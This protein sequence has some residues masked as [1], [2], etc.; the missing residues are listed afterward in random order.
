MRRRPNHQQASL[1]TTLITTI[2]FLLFQGSI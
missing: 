1:A 2:M